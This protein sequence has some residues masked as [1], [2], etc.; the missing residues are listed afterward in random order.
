MKR[1]LGSENA[2]IDRLNNVFNDSGI[3]NSSTYFCI[4]EFNDTFDS[5]I[6]NGLNLF[7]LNISSLT[8]NFDQLHTLLAGLDI[9]F[10]VLG[11][12]KTRLKLNSMPTNTFELEGYIIEH[13][14]T[15]SSCGGALLYIDHHI[16][17]KVCKDLKMYKAK[18]L[19]SIF[20]EILN[21][22]SKNN[23]WL[24]LSTSLHGPCRV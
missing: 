8:Y 13:T 16:N 4:K 7:R 14:P 9:K 19:E 2:L 22:N 21:Q 18:E 11:I 3:P 1:N 20:N 15:K 10:N 12:T 23:M 17:Y 24:Y 6:F 5:K